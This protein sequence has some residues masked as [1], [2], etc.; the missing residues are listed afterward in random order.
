M[1]PIRKIKHKFNAKRCE[2]ENIKFPSKLERDFY[3]QL[4]MRQVAGE[5]LFFLRQVP[6]ELLGGMKY[7][8]DFQ[9]F[10]SNGEIEFIDTK[11]FDTQLSIT[12][13]K[14]VEDAYPIEIKIIKKV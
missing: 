10:Y 14:M 2:Y 3:I 11:G 5:V 1:I 8:V 12:K 7:V 4:K 6:F 9:V 13:R